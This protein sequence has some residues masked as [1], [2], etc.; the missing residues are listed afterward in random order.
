[1]KLRRKSVKR[2]GIL[3]LAVGGLF[4]A[5][6]MLYWQYVKQVRDQLFADQRVGRNAYLA[7]EYAKAIDPLER[8]LREYPDD[9]KATLWFADSRFRVETGNNSHIRIA[10]DKLEH[11]L[12][13]EPNN[14]EAKN[15]L[16]EIYPQ[17]TSTDAMEKLAAD[18]LAKDPENWRALNAMLTTRL[19]QSRTE[20]GLQIVTELARVRPDDIRWKTLVMQLMHQLQKPN[21]VIL[22][23]ASKQYASDKDDPRYLLLQAFA[24][25]YANEGDKAL[26]YLQQA[27]AKPIGNP[28]TVRLLASIFDQMKRFDESRVLLE[29]TADRTQDPEIIRVLV[30][31]LWQNGR[32]ADIITRL[33]SLDVSSPKSDPELLALRAM[34]LYQSQR[35]SEARQIVAKLKERQDS[36]KAAAWVLAL[37]A[38]FEDTNEPQSKLA[39]KLTEALK[40]DLDNGIF[41]SWLADVYWNLGESALALRQWQAAAIAMPSWSKPY[42]GMSHAMLQLGRTADAVEAAR[43]AHERAPAASAV[44]LINY[45]EMRYRLFEETSDPAS[46]AE[47]LH[48]ATQILKARPNEPRT[49]PI[50]VALLARTGERDKALAMLDAVI[51]DRS[52]YTAECL[53][54]LAAASR[55]EG[56]DREIPLLAGVDD[57]MVTPRL[58]LTRATLLAEEGKTDEALADL[59]KRADQ[60][61]PGERV[62]WLLAIA[63]YLDAADHPT[64]S[65]NWHKLANDYAD[66][67]DVQRAALASRSVRSDRAFVEQTINRV[68]SITGEDGQQWKLERARWLIESPDVM[69]D[70][71]EAAFI[72]REIILNSPNQIEP[73]LL[74]ARAHELTGNVV[75]AIDHLR[76]AQ[77]IDP[78]SAQVTLELVRLLQKQGQTDQIRDV[79]KQLSANANMTSRQRVMLASLFADTGDTQRAIDLLTVDQQR[80]ALPQPGRLLLAELYRRNGSSKL[81]QALY[82]DL[83]ANSPTAG[84]L[85]SAAE[86][87]ALQG[88]LEQARKTLARLSESTTLTADAAIARAR[89]EERFGTTDAALAQY[90]AAADTKTEAG[91]VALIEYLVR[92]QDFA[93]AASVARSAQQQF[94]GSV[95]IANRMAEAQALATL[96]QNPKDLQPLIDALSRDA[97]RQAEVEA[98]KTL[99]EIQNSKLTPAEITARLRL[100]ADKHPRFLRLQE[101]VVENYLQ[102]RKIDDAV[103]VARRTMEALPTDPAAARLAVRTLRAAGRWQEMQ[104]AAEQWKTRAPGVRLDADTAVAEA[105][106]ELKQPDQAI[107]RLDPHRAAIERDVRTQTQSAVVLAR[108]MLASNRGQAARE[109]LQPMLKDTTGRRQWRQ[110]AV[111]AAPTLLEGSAWLDA[112][113]AATPKEEVDEQFEEARAWEALGRKFDDNASL[114]HAAVALNEYLTVRKQDGQALLLLGNIHHQLGRLQAAESALRAILGSKPDHPAA[115]ND[116]ACLLTAQNRS[117]DE[118]EKLARLAVSKNPDTASYHDTLARVLMARNQLDPAKASFETALRLDPELLDARVG[119]ARLLRQTGNTPAALRELD[120]VNTQL[121]ARPGSGKHL[122]TEIDALREQLSRND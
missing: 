105:L 93:Q 120:R 8:Y 1:M 85:A 106:I 59:R 110:L 83:L 21:A 56:L 90:R 20:E 118:A 89:F 28:D 36:R 49:L 97:S 12:A 104:L 116:L 71:V 65:D 27:A 48:V 87:Y 31:R 74:L 113:A 73:R 62:Q 44:T 5:G 2:I 38:R 103:T 53:I 15:L 80:G 88:D 69:R 26:W 92:T 115:A 67:L 63:R 42:L 7:H 112:V 109:M 91:T 3:V 24:A 60:S 95:V 81:A 108:A 30:T 50:M 119:L 111:V 40:R 107:A 4:A 78:R 79:L 82:A 33:S 100:V 34:A 52:K 86:F 55:N 98:L 13:R 68:K 101:Q 66:S 77:S 16:L 75:S 117:L 10:I 32:D 25:N 76:H 22:D 84:T 57:A 72:L 121:K 29:Q 18:V 39:E 14:M 99:Q 102:Q 35:T 11:V 114:E 64:A 51:A 61:K 9:S 43:A 6:G 45:A 19:R 94:P 58:A 70:G 47:V 17:T 37:E 96:Q 46:A 54:A 122:K 23:Y 41:R